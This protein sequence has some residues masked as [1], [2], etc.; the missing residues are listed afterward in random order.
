MFFAAFLTLSRPVCA[1]GARVSLRTGSLAAGIRASTCRASNALLWVSLAVL[2]PCFLWANTPSRPRVPE[3]L[4][5]QFSQTRLP[6]VFEPGAGGNSFVSRTGEQFAALRSDGVSLKIAGGRQAIRVAF[7]GA[8]PGASAQGVDPLPSYSNYFLGRKRSEWRNRVPQYRGVRYRGVYPGIDVVYYGRGG[9]LEYDFVIAPGADPSCIELR[10]E[11]VDQVRADANGDLRLRFPGGELVQ[12]RPRVY[13]IING[14]EQELA[15]GYRVRAHSE[16]RFTLARYDRSRELVIDPVLEYSQYT[17]SAGYDFGTGVAADAA[18]NVYVVGVTNGITFPTQDKAQ[19][20][21]GGA[22]DALVAKFTPDGA[23]L[24]VTY[25]GGSGTE[26]AQGLAVDAGG[27]VYISGE[28]TSNN[29]PVR[30]GFQNNFGGGFDDAFIT[31]IS[32]AGDSILWSTY[33][34]G[35]S[36]DFGNTLALDGQGNVYTTGWTRSTDFPVRNAFQAGPAGGGADIYVTKLAPAGNALVYST[37]VGGNGMDLAGGIAVDANG[38]AYVVGSSTST[39]FPTAGAIQRNNRGFADAVAFKLSPDGR[40]LVYSTFL[41]G[42]NNELAYRVAVDP[43][44]AAFITG[45]TQSADFPTANPVQAS[46]GGGTDV[47]VAKLAPDGQSLLFSTFLGGASDDYGFGNIVLDQAGSPYVTGWTQSPNFPNR[48]SIQSGFAGGKY[49]AFVTKLSPSGDSILYST[50]LGGSDEERTYGLAIDSRGFLTLVG[51]T[52]SEN[53]P[54]ARN[55]LVRGSGAFDLFMARLSADVSTA[56]VTATATTLSFSGLAGGAAPAAQ[57][58]QLSGGQPVPFTAAASA[59]WLEV[60][61]ASGL[62][63]AT[64]TVR[65]NPAGLVADTHRGAIT[66]NAPSA[67]NSPLSIPV[68][69]TLTAVPSVSALAPA[70]LSSGSG[71]TEV[72]VQGAG[73]VSASVVMAGTVPLVTTFLNAN[74]LR[75]VVPASLLASPGTLRLTVVN[76][77]AV[78]SNEVTLAVNPLGPFFTAASIVN[79]ATYLSG[80]VAPGEIATIFVIGLSVT[81]A[82]RSTPDLQGT[83]PAVLAGTR[84]F[85][86]GTA[87]PVISVAPGQVSAIVPYTLAGRN[88]AVVEIESGVSRSTPVGVNLLSSAPGIF[89][90]DASGRGQAAALNQNGSRNSPGSPAQKG[91]VVTLFLTGEGITDPPGVAGRI[92]SAPDLP[93]PVLPVQVRIAGVSADVQFAAAAPGQAAVMQLNVLIPENAPSGDAVPIVV[94][95]G[96]GSSQPGV[97]VAIQ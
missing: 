25:L 65:V 28:T 13:Q 83:L 7:R 14:R 31:K 77:G 40:S 74:T 95:V 80:G 8:N 56:F 79:A 87:A 1:R 61:P 91:S 82:V 68:T 23:M 35:G 3:P 86:D 63:P 57:T 50:P 18:G 2:C 70:T 72:T 12:R 36:D 81:E 85:F 76:P 9:K 90:A 96:G 39:L 67:S 30:N 32:P 5:L 42:S 29:F 84:V 6:V 49:D 69:F 43:S 48:N 33:L 66:I 11:G 17:G 62:T 46:L 4:K 19:E 94:N 59:P 71:D 41:G 51:G 16:A 24:W 58:I 52:R 20:L 45:Y 34:G 60:T 37:F 64:L 44:G 47:F 15:G 75:V 73:F 54:R 55:S 22:T 38:S 21:H 88:S 93:R 27:N 92:A 10:F 26:Q 97:T 53:L 78:A 89:T